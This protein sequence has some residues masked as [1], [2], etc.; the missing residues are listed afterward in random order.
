VTQSAD[1]NHSQRQRLGH[2]ALAVTIGVSVAGFLIG[3]RELPERR[4]SVV[5]TE[6]SGAARAG[7]PPVVVEYLKM[8]KVTRGPNSNWT[9]SLPTHQDDPTRLFG[10][11]SATDQQRAA[12]VAIRGELRAF[13][14]APPV[15]P[16]AIDER[17]A[18]ACLACHGAGF[19][20]GQVIAPKM[21]HHYL[22]NCTQCHVEGA[23]NAPWAIA[24][25]TAT[26]SQFVGLA[27]PGRGERI[28]PG[29]PPTIP[30]SV[31]MRSECVTCHGSL[32]KEGLRTS[33]PWRVNCTQCHA[34]S[35][36]FDWAPLEPPLPLPHP[37]KKS[38]GPLARANI[39]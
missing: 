23:Q 7:L 34:P 21:S 38:L 18:Q 26:Q 28:G 13:S 10:D 33:H 3:A 36:G 24:S 39:P 5:A 12:A 17:N 2:M 9:Q 4:R 11:Q 8:S 35:R 30:H 25:T 14:G 31:W 20:V 15:V 6:E 27:E 16:H 19:K 32:G 1:Q 29:A 37:Q 22:P